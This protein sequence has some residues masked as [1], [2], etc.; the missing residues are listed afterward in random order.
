MAKKKKAEAAAGAVMLPKSRTG[1]SGFDQITEGGLPTGRPSLVC[2]GAGSGKTMFAVEFLVKGAIDYDEPGL[3]VAFE[4]TA[5][6]LTQNVAS[7]GFDLTE[8]TAQKKIILDHIHIER[9][10]IEVTGEYDLEG[11]FVRLGY[12]LDSIKAKRIV[13]DTLEALF[14]SLPSEAILRAELRRLFR[15]LK[16][17]GVTAIIT[18]ERGG[19]DTLT[20]HGLEEYVSDCVILLDHRV[21]EQISTRRLRI[22]KYRG[23]YHGTNEYPFL[24]ERAGISILPISSVELKHQVSSERFPTGIPALDAMLDGG[25]YQG[26]TILISG[27][28]G[29]GKSTFAAACAVAACRAGRKAM[30]FAFEESESQIIRNMRS[31]GLDLEP[32]VRQGLL[33]FQASRPTVYGLEMHLVRMHGLIE[34]FQPEVV[35]MDPISNMVTMG[36]ER[37]VNSMLSR[38]IDYLKGRGIT[39]VF[40]TLAHPETTEM[41]EV[42]ISSLIDTWLLLRLDEFS[43]ERNRTLF[44][45]KSRGMAHSNQ[46]REL[47]LSSEG[48]TFIEA[49]VGEGKVF[50]G[51]A[52]EVQEARDRAEAMARRQEIERLRR[53]HERQQ[54][55]LTAQIETLKVQLEQEE[56][57]LGLAETQESLREEARAV[58]RRRQA[59]LRHME[60]APGR[61][62]EAPKKNNSRKRS[63]S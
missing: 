3:F 50:T 4:E 16:E 38:L 49:Y 44:I 15:W 57:E 54:R 43:G 21:I 47:R 53:S 39:A 19:E 30:Y 9:S 45:L 7:L 42:A 48:I 11:L 51:S 28:A 40:T 61:P 1:I 63:G 17:R 2:G 13:I 23:S 20:R 41:T 5:A 34:E 25:Y 8:L 52:R 14:A 36:S 58:D 56:E 37:E 10:E 33:R 6:D 29:A 31:V 24:I 18:A 32:C 12:L 46:V 55:L 59:E 60:A 27:T 22:V 62:S 35:M 26:S